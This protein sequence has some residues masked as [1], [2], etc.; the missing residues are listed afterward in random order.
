MS[1]SDNAMTVLTNKNRQINFGIAIP[2]SNKEVMDNLK[3]QLHVLP[4]IQCWHSSCLLLVNGSQWS[5]TVAD[6]L[7]L[8]KQGL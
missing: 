2:K 8:Q 5:D 1:F 4:F 6:V 7:C 3:T